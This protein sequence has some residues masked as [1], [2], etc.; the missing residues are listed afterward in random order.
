M[1]NCL[2]TSFAVINIDWYNSIIMDDADTKV[3][4]LGVVNV[5]YWSTYVANTD[6]TYH[7]EC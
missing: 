4:I 2:L 7:L 5:K 3:A 1:C 6:T